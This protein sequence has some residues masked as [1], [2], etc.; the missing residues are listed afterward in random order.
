VYVKEGA[1]MIETQSRFFEGLWRQQRKT[2]V[3]F[4]TLFRLNQPVPGYKEN[5]IKG[6]GAKEIS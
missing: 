6:E 1:C 5:S 4:I 2:G 3:V